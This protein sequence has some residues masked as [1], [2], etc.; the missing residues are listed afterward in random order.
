LYPSVLTSPD[1]LEALLLPLLE[2]VAVDAVAV[3]LAVLLAVALAVHLH[4][5]LAV[6][7]KLIV[8]F[9]V[10]NKYLRILQLPWRLP[11]RPWQRLRSLLMNQHLYRSQQ[12]LATNHRRSR[13]L[14]YGLS[15]F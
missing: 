2:A 3:A 13:R 9:L 14:S 11:W 12:P 4:L 6:A 15:I 7:G 8:Y 1:S 5:P 10:L